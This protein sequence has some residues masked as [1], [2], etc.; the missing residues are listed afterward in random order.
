MS[1][2]LDKI[3]DTFPANGDTAVPLRSAITITL[4]GVDFDDDSLEEGLFLEGP[5]TDKYIGPGLL[6]QTYPNNISE[7]DLDDFL[8]SPGYQGIVDGDVTVTGVAGGTLVT[9]TPTLPLFP[10]TDYIVNFCGIKDALL[11][12]ID[13]F[14]TLDF[15]SGSG[16]I[17]TIPDTISSS[18]LSDGAI[19][20]FEPG[21][22]AVDTDP[23][24]IIGTTPAND[25]VQVATSLDEI[26]IEFS[27][28]IDPTSVSAENISVKVIPASDHPNASQSVLDDIAKTVEVDGKILTIKI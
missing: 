17:E 4:S 24:V 25:A 5:D 10:S 11:V 3:I 7:G 28:A 20:T 22:I 16:S 27:E 2:L 6:T 9:F 21:V 1:D 15:Q 18:V 12:D 23:L 19:E 26:T 14:V 8:N 13:G